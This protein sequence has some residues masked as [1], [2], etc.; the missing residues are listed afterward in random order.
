M[1]A[2]VDW[3]LAFPHAIVEILPQHAFDHNAL[4]LSCSKFRSKRAKL[5]HFQ[6]AWM[7]H[8]DYNILVQNTWSQTNGDVATKLDSIKKNSLAFNRDTFG[9]IFKHKRRIEAHIWGVHLQLDLAPTSNLI[10]LERDIQQQ[11]SSVL[12]EE[13]ML[14][15][16]K[17]RENWLIF[18]NKN[19]KFYHAQTVIHRRHNKVAS[20]Q[21]EGEKCDDENILKREAS[22]FFKNLF[23]F[24]DH[25]VPTS[26]QLTYIPQICQDL[27]VD[28]LHVVSKREVCD[29]LFSMAPY[30]APDSDGFQPIFFCSYWNILSRDIWELV[31]QAF[32]TGNIAPYLA[33]TLIVPIPKVDEPKTL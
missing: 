25:C 21:I 9:N 20:L 8:S 24:I 12:E 1:V 16:Q 13:E 29:A 3:Q 11:Y 7:S 17:S 26:L 15:S 10:H 32:S 5:F 33:K 30:K 19:T 4:L 18:G 22:S 14:W 23:R 31:A 2:D 27:K 6:A 28:L